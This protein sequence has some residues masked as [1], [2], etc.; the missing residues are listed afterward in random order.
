[1]KV[2]ATLWEWRENF[3]RVVVQEISGEVGILFF[4]VEVSR[5]SD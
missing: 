2:D 3:G 1:M 4:E 5:W